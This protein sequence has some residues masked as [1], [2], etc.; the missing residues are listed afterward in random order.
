MVPWPP[1]CFNRPENLQFGSKHNHL[2]V[3][4]K[5]GKLNLEQKCYGAISRK[6]A[7]KCQKMTVFRP[8]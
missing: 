8:P 2:Q 1:K 3:I 6:I 7:E 4:K 5:L